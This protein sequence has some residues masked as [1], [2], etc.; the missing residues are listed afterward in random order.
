M[1]SCIGCGRV[2]ASCGRRGVAGASAR[3]AA[4]VP[5]QGRLPLATRSSPG[6][7]NTLDAPREPTTL[8]SQ[9]PH[10]FP[11][12]GPQRSRPW[13]ARV[14]TAAHL[15]NPV[16][17]EHAKASALATNALLSH[18]LEVAGSL[19]LGDT[20]VHR[21]AVHDALQATRVLR[22]VSPGPSPLQAPCPWNC[23]LRTAI[24]PQ[25]R[26]QRRSPLQAVA[27]PPNALGPMSQGSS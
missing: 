10:P 6:R 19:E 15:V 20:L 8:P 12:A 9:P 27:R 2:S 24:R 16:G 23:T 13:F 21:L 17:V 3:A 22:S 7:S 11:P 18:V 14:A 4:S 26:S 25:R 1:E 5:A